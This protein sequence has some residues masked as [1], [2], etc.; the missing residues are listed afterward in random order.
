MTVCLR[1]SMVRASEIEL[2]GTDGK[3]YSL[4]FVKN[5]IEN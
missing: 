3:K 4:N 1:I 5:Y 2:I